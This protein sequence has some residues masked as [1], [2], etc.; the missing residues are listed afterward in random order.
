MWVIL[1]GPQWGVRSPLVRGELCRERRAEVPAV[2]AA[3]ARRSRVSA[4]SSFTRDSGAGG[5]SRNASAAP[6]QVLRRGEGALAL[7][8]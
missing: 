6:K 1:P 3:A 4:A 7:A 2:W 5:L 8:G